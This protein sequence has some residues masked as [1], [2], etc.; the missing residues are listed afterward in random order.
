MAGEPVVSLN[1]R[2][3]EEQDVDDAE[4]QKA[5]TVSFKL[6]PSVIKAIDEI[7]DAEFRSRSGSV[8]MALAQ[9]IASRKKAGDELG[10]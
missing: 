10:S 4:E 2:K 7:S 3:H 1:D 9:F 5:T 8:R 6:Q